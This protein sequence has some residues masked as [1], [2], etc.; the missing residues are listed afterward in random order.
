MNELAR[1][2]DFLCTVLAHP[3]PHLRNKILIFLRILSSFF[4]TC[5]YFIYFS[6]D[7]PPFFLASLFHDRRALIKAIWLDL[8]IDTYF[9]KN[10][11]QSY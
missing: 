5:H 9:M 4:L 1:Y 6:K 3:F 8:F 2:T 7:L 10:S 11:K